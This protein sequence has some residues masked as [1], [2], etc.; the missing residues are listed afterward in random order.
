MNQSND[1]LSDNMPTRLLKK[2]HAYH[3]M[4]QSLGADLI[5]NSSNFL[6]YAFF[7]NKML[8]LSI[9]SLDNGMAFLEQQLMVLF[10][11]LTKFSRVELQIIL[12]S[13]DHRPYSPIIFLFRNVAANW[14]IPVVSLPR[15]TDVFWHVEPNKFPVP[16]MRLDI[17]LCLSFLHPQFHTM[18]IS[19]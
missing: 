7:D 2:S 19:H 16:K 8:S 12:W 11:P 10:E 4:A 17:L 5:N 6:L 1:I 15:R 3:P 14:K 9:I 13:S 18:R